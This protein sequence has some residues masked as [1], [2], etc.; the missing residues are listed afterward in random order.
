MLFLSKMSKIFQNKQ[1]L[2]T[3]FFWR[4]ESHDL[5]RNLNN[6]HGRWGTETIHVQQLLLSINNMNSLN[7]YHQQIDK[8]M[9]DS[10]SHIGVHLH[11]FML[12]VPSYWI[13]M[14]SCSRIL[15][16]DDDVSVFLHDDSNL[17]PYLV[18]HHWCNI[19]RWQTIQTGRPSNDC[20][21]WD[22]GPIQ[23]YVKMP[24]QT[25]HN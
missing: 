14:Y 20:A 15:C 1:H 13:T 18:M 3:Y 23:T 6:Q 22:V 19:C 4:R 12:K 2:S 25:D 17:F 10:Q 7:I 8:V 11:H 5:L 16:D 24:F 21:F 9:L